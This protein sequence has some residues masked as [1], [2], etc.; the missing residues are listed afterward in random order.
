MGFPEYEGGRNVASMHVL[1]HEGLW[2]GC[3]EISEVEWEEAQSI[4]LC[5]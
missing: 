5:E 4:S 1:E 2:R 3:Q